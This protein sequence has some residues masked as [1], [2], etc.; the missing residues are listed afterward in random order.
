MSGEGRATAR[1]GQRWSGCGGEKIRGN[2]GRNE[3]GPGR[4]NGAVIGQDKGHQHGERPCRGHCP[5]GVASA[6]ALAALRV[7]RIGRCRVVVL[8]LGDRLGLRRTGVQ[9]L[10][11]APGDT[12][13]EE[14]QG[15]GHGSTAAQQ[16]QHED[17]LGGGALKRKD[18]PLRSVTLGRSLAVLGM[19][20]AWSGFCHGRTRPGFPGE[21]A[22][23]PRRP[24]GPVRPS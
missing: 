8:M 17:K 14:H 13:S 19:R 20:I 23:P 3:G 4:Q 7:A 16:A 5:R 9:P 1:S 18:D 24:A 2:A 15:Q 21:G 12:R 6:D 10:H 11:R 22:A